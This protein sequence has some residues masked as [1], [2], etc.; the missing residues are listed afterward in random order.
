[1]TIGLRLRHGFFLYGKAILELQVERENWWLGLCFRI[2]PPRVRLFCEV[3]NNL[4]RSIDFFVVRLIFDGT[5]AEDLLG[6]DR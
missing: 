5:S 1:M 6:N 4:A 3:I 2:S